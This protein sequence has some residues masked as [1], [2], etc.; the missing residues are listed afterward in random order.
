ML[1]RGQVAVTDFFIAAV[2][3]AIIVTAIMLSW[4]SYNRK[5]QDQINYNELIIK[6]FHASELLSKYPGR[7]TAWETTG[8]VDLIGLA[9]EK[10]L[11]SEAKLLN[12][13]QRSY[14][15][16]RRLLNLEA[17]GFYFE[18]KDAVG[19]DFSPSIIGSKSGNIS[20]NIRRFVVYK[21]QEAVLEVSVYE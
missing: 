6:G 16:T 11:I 20:V 8:E 10:N 17:Y 12:F 19:N 13:T 4:N 9:D 3:F 15:E 1:K 18:L 14:D 21:N 5:I 2:I 7:P